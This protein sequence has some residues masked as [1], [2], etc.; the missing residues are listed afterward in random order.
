MPQNAEEK[1]LERALD[2]F[3]IKINRGS[4]DEYPIRLLGVEDYNVKDVGKAVNRV[5]QVNDTTVYFQEQDYRNG[6]IDI[7]FNAFCWKEEFELLNAV[8][9]KGIS[10]DADNERIIGITDIYG[11]G[12]NYAII[13]NLVWERAAY[14]ARE[15]VHLVIEIAVLPDPEDNVFRPL[16]SGETVGSVAVSYLIESCSI[17]PRIVQPQTIFGTSDKLQILVTSGYASEMWDVTMA[18]IELIDPLGLVTSLMRGALTK[19][20]VSGPFDFSLVGFYT[21]QLKGILSDI[22]ISFIQGSP[23]FQSF[24]ITCIVVKSENIITDGTVIESWSITD[25]SSRASYFKT[26]NNYIY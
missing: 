10:S 3:E 9:K 21:S 14:N 2:I 6:F 26:L 18:G 24:N 15:A 22:E 4:S 13:T 20:I 8:Y 19:N 11:H 16:K 7:T 5:Q 25:I 17:K 1:E 12:Y 23:S